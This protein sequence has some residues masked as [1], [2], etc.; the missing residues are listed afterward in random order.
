MESTLALIRRALKYL[1]GFS[2]FL[3]LL[4]LIPAMFM[5]QVFDRVLISRSQET[6]I[7]LLAGAAIGLGMMLLLDF[8]RSRLQ[9]LLGG[10]V[11]EIIQPKIARQLLSS[12]ELSDKNS[13]AA[14]LRDAGSVQNMLSSPAI[15]A[16]IDSPWLIIYSAVIAAFHPALGI[17]AFCA[18][19]IMLIITLSGAW[20]T[21]KDIRQLHDEVGKSNRYFTNAVRN[22]EAI[23]ALGIGETIT[24]QWRARAEKGART[25]ARLTPKTAAFSALSRAFRQVVQVSILALG[26]YLVIHDLATPGIMIATTI[27]LG[28]ALQPMEQV[29]GHWRVLVEGFNG[30]KNLKKLIE[31]EQSAVPGAHM[32]LPPPK[33]QISVESVSYK[34]DGSDHLV[35]AGVSFELRAG[36]SLAIIGPTSAGKSTL[37]RLLIGIEKPSVGAIRYDGVDVSD[38]PREELGP[39]IGYIPQSVQLFEGTIAQNIA[40]MQTV[41]PSQVIEAAER[42]NVHEMIL[43]LPAGYDTVFDPLNPNL[44]P[45][46]CQRIALA[47]AVFGDPK[48]LIFDEPNSN[49]DNAGEAALVSSLQ[50]MRSE[51]RTVI[52]ITHRPS[53]MQ[54]AED[55]LV[56]EG[57][58]VAQFGPI[59][60]LMTGVPQPDKTA[61]GQPAPRKTDAPEPR[62]FRSGRQ[63]G[64]Q[65][66]SKDAGDKPA[67][68]DF[69]RRAGSDQAVKVSNYRMNYKTSQ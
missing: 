9:A 15:V 28:R 5:I 52:V 34:P 63:A 64:K 47:R 65:P 58:R 42:A 22:A 46:Q 18:A 2:I 29:V 20:F 4:M 32:K 60:S 39:G 27:L 1:V 24:N 25:Q 69:K 54:V 57:G 48:I 40:R 38:W 30:Y 21:R 44:S 12:G 17:A 66:E 43:S 16:V 53:L 7:V 14:A 67:K 19:L 62:V 23:H 31:K 41:D 36:Q 13:A 3:N 11:S 50:R 45:G 61:G 55:V 10:I 59:K 68:P 49:L 51:G 6:L 33:G 56:L 37:A 35:L 26:A 8:V